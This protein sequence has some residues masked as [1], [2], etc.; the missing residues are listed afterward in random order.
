MPIQPNPD[1]HCTRCGEVLSEYHHCWQCHY[2]P[3][4]PKQDATYCDGKCGVCMCQSTPSPQ[5][6]ATK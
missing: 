2:P 6:T 3:M 4:D 5:A 1:T